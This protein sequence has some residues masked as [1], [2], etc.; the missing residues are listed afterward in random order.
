MELRFLG[1]LSVQETA[2]VLRISERTVLREWN[3]ARDIGKST[4]EDIK[5]TAGVPAPADA[6]YTL[7]SR[8]G[9]QGR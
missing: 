3:L 2:A 7:Y 1:G 8:S 9:E 4:R 6:F 5:G